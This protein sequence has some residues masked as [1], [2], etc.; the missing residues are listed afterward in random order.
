MIKLKNLVEAISDA[1]EQA[2]QNLIESEENNLIKDFFDEDTETGNYSAKTI[3]I[4]YPMIDNNGE[5]CKIPID[6]PRI[7][8]VP[9]SPPI[10]EELKFT[11]NLD[12]ALNEDEVMVSFSP[13]SYTPEDS[14]KQNKATALLEITI[15]PGEKPEG[16]HKLIE[17]YEKFLRA[18]IPG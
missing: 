1:A 6:V 12:I 16:L 7:T 10:I 8:L 17:G 2:N 9:I 4:D 18:Q 14:E 5:L 13:K 3:K 11:T 15:K